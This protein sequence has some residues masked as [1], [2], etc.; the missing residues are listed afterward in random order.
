MKG[1]NMSNNSGKISQTKYYQ[2]EQF[3]VDE[4]FDIWRK[5]SGKCCHCGKEIY[6]G[7]ANSMTV[8]HF[9]PLFNFCISFIISSGVK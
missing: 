5:S 7:V 2:R 1:V 4:K 3:S 8:D 6:P 9:I